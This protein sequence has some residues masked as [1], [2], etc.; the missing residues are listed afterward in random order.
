MITKNRVAEFRHINKLTQKDLADKTNVSLS[1]IKLLENPKTDESVGLKIAY[2]L[3]NTLN[4][5]M[6]TLFNLKYK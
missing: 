2:K 6:E 1:Y 5:D 3:A 4:T